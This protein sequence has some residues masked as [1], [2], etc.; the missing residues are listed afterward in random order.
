MTTAAAHEDAVLVNALEQWLP[1]RLGTATTEVTDLQRPT[2]GSSA[3]TCLFNARTAEGATHRLVVRV[4]AVGDG[5]FRDP[6]VL[7]D[8]GVQRAV[9]RSGL[10]PVPSVLGAEADAAL[11]G[12]PF[13]V[14]A[15]AAGRAIPDVPSCHQTGWLCELDP[16]TRAA[17]WDHG[18][19]ALVA[20]GRVDEVDGIPVGLDGLVRETRAW[21]DW[22]A[23]GRAL[24][25]L[26]EAMAFVEQEQPAHDE[27]TL[28]WGDAR[29][30]N[31]LFAPDG[32]VNAVL[33]WEMAA[34]APA[35]VDLGWWL[36]ADEFYADGMG[37]R[38]LDGVP[39]EAAVVARWEELQGR[40][41]RDLEY[42][43]VLGSL[44][45]AIVLVRARD[46]SVA[47]GALPRDATMHVANPLTQMLARAL[48]L[49]VPPLAPEYQ[50]MLDAY[51]ER[52]V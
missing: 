9:A 34:L 5:L 13:V 4:Q 35:E 51:V 7:R 41:A 3:E 19:K 17:H 32:E 1:R 14:M 50:A 44:R 15:R 24:A 46:K 33:D 47:A 45:F 11:L 38:R 2:A 42:Y 37:V 20:L 29:V 52:G 16:V 8:V 22:A 21:F 43:K 49:R 10:V 36:S 40:A 28:S 25:V 12:A 48:G 31:F 18:L 27:R 39:D 30:G 6:D 23:D 26:D